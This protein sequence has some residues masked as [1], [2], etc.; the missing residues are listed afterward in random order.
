MKKRFLFIVR[1]VVLSLIAS[2]V[3]FA[4]VA[5]IENQFDIS[6][7]AVHVKFAFYSL[8]VGIFTILSLASW[9]ISGG[10]KTTK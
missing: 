10:W 4:I 1:F 8:E 9:I 5:T 7:W 2:V 6:C 3:S